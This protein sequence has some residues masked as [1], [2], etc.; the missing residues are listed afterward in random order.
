MLTSMVSSGS[1]RG[2]WDGVSHTPAWTGALV[3]GVF[4]GLAKRFAELFLLTSSPLFGGRPVVFLASDST[5]D[6]VLESGKLA[7][8]SKLTRFFET[9]TST[10][11]A[12][13]GAIRVSSRF[14]G[15]A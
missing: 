13:A 3:A 6:C 7:S 12:S 10:G 8:S 14:G 11:G 1:V 2:A 15:P 9:L 5:D 4:V